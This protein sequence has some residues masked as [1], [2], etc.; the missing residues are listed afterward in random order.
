MLSGLLGVGGGLVKVPV[1]NLC[2]GVPL[3]RPPPQATS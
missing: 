3:R 2:M 1:M